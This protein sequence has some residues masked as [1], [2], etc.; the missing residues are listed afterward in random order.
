MTNPE[1]RFDDLL[2]CAVEAAR[3]AGEHA[4]RNLHRRSE[5]AHRFAHDVKLHLDLES[6]QRAEQVIRAAFPSH[7]ILGEE[8]GALTSG[9][10]PLWIIDPIDGTVNFSHGLPLWCSSVAVRVGGEV[11]AG[12]VHL[13]AMRE[14]YTATLGQPALCNGE[15]IRVSETAGLE[16]ALVLTG[17]PMKKDHNMPTLGMVRAVSPRV[18]KIRVMGAAA[19]DICYVA[20]GRADGYFESGIYLWDVAAAGLVAQQAG[21]R[22]EVLEHLTDVRLRYICTNGRIH[23]ALKDIVVQALRE[24]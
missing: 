7:H 15:P 19:V 16:E 13:P 11:V 14:T 8:D 23:D 21:A 6:Q 18:Q 10:E 17:L 12:A 4:F 9:A 5:V 24:I 22:V 2:A 20:C 1:C 3:A